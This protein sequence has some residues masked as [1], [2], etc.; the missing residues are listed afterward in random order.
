MQHEEPS[1]KMFDTQFGG[2][3]RHYREA[4]EVSQRDLAR[5]VTALG[6]SVDASGI[7]RIEKGTR[8]VKLFEAV[9]LA[10]ALDV[11]LDYLIHGQSARAELNT[12]R[13]ELS[14]YL[15]EFHSSVFRV[16]TTAG[17][18]EDMLATDPELLASLASSDQEPPASAADYPGWVAT[19]AREEMSPPGAGHVLLSGD[20]EQTKRLRAMLF[21]IIKA[22]LPIPSGENLPAM[23]V[24]D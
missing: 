3:V 6:A 20:I 14:R 23:G 5:R 19:R 10:E 16:A 9:A 15:K 18:I 2:R 1:E 24:D 21:D 22:Q 7:S 4:Q 13:N 17:D 11:P 12:I 8:T